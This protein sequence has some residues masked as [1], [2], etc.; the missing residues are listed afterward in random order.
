MERGWL[1]S[2]VVACLLDD[3]GYHPSLEHRVR[4]GNW[5]RGNLGG[6]GEVREVASSS[7]IEASLDD[8]IQRWKN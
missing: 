6:G 8:S 1:I 5:Q 7:M 2:T 4:R 3:A